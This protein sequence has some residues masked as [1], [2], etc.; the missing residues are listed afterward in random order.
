MLNNIHG[1]DIDRQAVEV[2]K[3]SLLLKVLEGEND[4]TIS[5]QLKL[6]QERALPDLSNNIK[7]GNSLIGWDILKDHPDMEQEEIDRI[8]PFDWEKEFPVVFEQGGFDVV[9]GNPPYIR[10]EIFKEIKKY[11]KANFISHSERA[12][13]YVYFIEKCH[14]ILKE[15]GHFGM[16]VSNK[17]LRSN[18]GGPIRDF[19]RQNA[20]VERIVDFAGLPVFQGATV[21]TIIL[22]T[23]REQIMGP[24]LYSPPMSVD[25]FD[26]LQRGALSV[27]QVIEETT[28][29]VDPVVLSEL[30]W[31]FAKQEE[32]QL[33]SKIQARCQPLIYYCNGQICRGIVSGLTDAFVIDEEQRDKILKAN[34]D[35]LEIIKPFLKGR[36]VR[37]YNIE[38]KGDYL[39]Y[40]Y[41]GIDMSKYPSVLQYLRQFKD[42]LLNR[43]TKQ[44][45]YELQQPQ[46][47]YV[48]YFDNPKILFPD[49]AI[50]PRFT[51]D[52]L[53]YYGANTVY[54]IPLKDFYLLGL[55]NSKLVHRNKSYLS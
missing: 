42:R 29:E 45:W 38:T 54:F 33:L 41:H 17:F 10:M 35:A 52:E 20:K 30:T 34:P 25:T 39:I 4:E 21:R 36:D 11:L 13:M 5:K 28:Y 40:T 53:G 43:A 2:T 23:S 31:S 32:N 6:F 47:N 9:I 1:V 37:R 16:I 55:L 27:E 3:L 26:S 15:H 22:L 14:K 18:Y 50:K 8:N 19:I 48:K 51:I 46:Y 24:I 44:E 12:D 7:C 49:I